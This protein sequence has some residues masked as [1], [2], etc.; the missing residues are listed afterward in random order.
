MA[1]THAAMEPWGTGRTFVNLHGTPGDERDRARAWPAATYE[2]LC[3]VKHRYDPAGLLRFG[4][5]VSPLADSE[6]AS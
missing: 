6:V 2:R 1:A 5:A 4:H 3:R